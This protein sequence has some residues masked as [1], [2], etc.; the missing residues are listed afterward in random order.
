MRNEVE[1][2]E[3][4]NVQVLH[5]SFC[6]SCTRFIINDKPLVHGQLEY[7]QVLTKCCLVARVATLR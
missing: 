6:C 2:K 7:F 5:T 3:I 1:E 4:Y